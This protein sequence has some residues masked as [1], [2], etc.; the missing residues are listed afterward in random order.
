MVSLGFDSK[1]LSLL[2]QTV[3]QKK[4]Y[5][6]GRI[7]GLL[8][9]CLTKHILPITIITFR[10]EKILIFSLGKIRC[11]P[12]VGRGTVTTTA[13]LFRELHREG[14]IMPTL[15]LAMLFTAYE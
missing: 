11:K 15:L 5:L 4:S 8:V 9:V 6:T 7:Q 12:S 10:K 13:I 2:E 1:E 14:N 3:N